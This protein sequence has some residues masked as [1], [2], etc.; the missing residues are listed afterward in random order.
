MC[1][2]TVGGLIH[3][4]SIYGRSRSEWTNLARWVIKYKV[5]VVDPETGADVGKIRWMVQIPR[6]C[7]IFMGTAYQNFQELMDNIFGPMFEATLEPGA[8]PELHVLLCN[9]GALDSVDD[10]SVFDPLTRDPVAPGKYTEKANPPCVLF[11]C[12]TPGVL[13]GD[14]TTASSDTH[15]NV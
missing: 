9:L 15:C 10:E 14:A 2:R 13:V 4:L 8:H 7:N 11:C 6:L 1:G 3:R 12:V 5:L